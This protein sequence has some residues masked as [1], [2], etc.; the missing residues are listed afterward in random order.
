[1]VRIFTER[2]VLVSFLRILCRQFL[3]I[4][5]KCFISH[6]S[7]CTF[8]LTFVIVTVPAFSFF[9]LK[10]QSNVELQ[11]INFGLL[12]KYQTYKYN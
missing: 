1:M 8:I 10:N 11:N 5:F 7:S 3:P 9:C 6:C 4:R 2:V 12:R